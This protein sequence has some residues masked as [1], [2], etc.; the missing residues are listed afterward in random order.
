[1][2]LRETVEETIRELDGLSEALVILLGATLASDEL[3]KITENLKKALRE[4]K[5]QENGR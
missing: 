2:G 1:M 4:D 5:G 3:N